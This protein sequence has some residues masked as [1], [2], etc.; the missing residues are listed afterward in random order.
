[1]LHLSSFAVHRDVHRLPM[2]APH[3]ADFSE[4]GMMAI[5][6]AQ[7]LPIGSGGPCLWLRSRLTA[8]P[9]PQGLSCIY[10]SM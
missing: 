7:E 5:F 6:P 2:K 9:I 1:M 4:L 10:S 8:E 3:H